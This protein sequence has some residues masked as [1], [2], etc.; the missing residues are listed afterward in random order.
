MISIDYINNGNTITES[1]NKI[2]ISK[3]YFITSDDGVNNACVKVPGYKKPC[4]GRS[5]MLILKNEDDTWK[6]FFYKDNEKDHEY[7]AP[8]GGWNKNEDPK[9][10]AIREAKEECMMNV[11]DVKYSGYM[12][13]YHDKVADWVKDHVENKDDWWY[14]YYSEIFVGLYDSKFTGK[15]ADIDKDKEISS[16]KFY[17]FDDIKDDKGLPKEY[18]KAIESYIEGSSYVKESV[19]INE[20]DIY[21]NKDKFDSGEINLCFI[22]GHS[23]SGKSTMGLNATKGNEDKV[24][25]YS[26][27]DLQWSW[28]FSDD[29]LKEYGDLIYSFFNGSGKKYRIPYRIEKDGKLRG[30]TSDDV[31]KWYN[32]NG[33]KSLTDYVDKA[34]NAFIDYAI[35]Y[36]KSNKNKKYIIE[37]IQL[38]LFINPNKLKDYAVYIKG[39]SALISTLRGVKR[40]TL[41]PTHIVDNMDMFYRRIKDTI[42]I[43]GFESKISQYRKYFSNLMKEKEVTEACKDLATA[44]KFASEVKELAKKY[45][46]NF[47]LVTDGA[48]ATNNDGSNNA[49]KHARDTM[50]KWETEHGFDAKE[51]WS[52]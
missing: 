29:N 38:F 22:T 28:K 3:P 1:Y 43:N 20:K 32:D 25:T 18:K 49:V 47:Y 33:F 14:G 6:V 44:R 10:A 41:G 52:K 34:S 2:N 45:D 35:R 36:A 46:A 26:L 8:G 39:T 40:D 51:D 31:N 23:G 16:G 12:V 13:E 48:S 19:L 11:K 15:I 50:K 17:I 30:L 21:Y 27:D 42:G 37:G 24:N 5:S 4:R 9:D 7:H